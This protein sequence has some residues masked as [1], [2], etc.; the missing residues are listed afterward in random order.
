MLRRRRRWWRMAECTDA[1]RALLD[2]LKS[3]MGI[4]EARRKLGIASRDPQ[5]LERAV[6]AGLAVNAAREA[7][8]LAREAYLDGLPGQSIEFDACWEHIESE[9]S[10]RIR[11][12]DGMKLQWVS[13]AKAVQA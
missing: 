12:G 5:L 2:A 10:R 9:V 11:A 3:G 6:Q 8:Q 13:D 1:E 7:E 4:T